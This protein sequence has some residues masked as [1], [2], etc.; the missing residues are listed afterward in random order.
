MKKL[1]LLVL[2][3]V[4]VAAST[5]AGAGGYLAKQENPRQAGKSSIYFYDV[6]SKVDEGYGRLVI[7]VAKK[8]FVFIGQDFTPYARF[9]LK[10]DRESGWELLADGHA[11]RTGNLHIQ[12]EWK[13]GTSVPEPGMVGT[14]WYYDPAYGFNGQQLGGYIAR[15]KV[16]YSKDGGN[17]WATT[18][19]ETGDIDLGKTFSVT[20]AQFTDST[21]V[22]NKGDLIQFKV[23]VIG[24]DDTWT[25]T[26]FTYVPDGDP[27]YCWP[28]VLP[29]GT[30]FNAWIEYWNDQCQYCLT[31]DCSLYWYIWGV[32]IP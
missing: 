23:K 19:K 28:Y 9:K 7:D 2:C 18:E 27:A 25:D 29:R 13:T 16:R 12:G 26:W 30:T 3:F 21:H 8:T 5:Q 24:G 11:T 17:T 22:I 4:L 1:F 15:L 20:V 31:G 6:E 32:D 14:W 10:I